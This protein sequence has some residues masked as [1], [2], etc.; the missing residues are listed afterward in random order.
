MKRFLLPLLLFGALLLFLGAGLRRDPRELPS[1]LIGKPVPAFQASRLDD[2]NATLA[3][4]DMQGRVWLLNV[5][6]SWCEACRAEHADL[7]ELSK[8]LGAPLVGLNYKDG[9][10]EALGWLQRYGNPYQQT[11]FDPDGRVGIEFG[12]YGVPETF[13]IDKRG[14]IRMKH[15]GPLNTPEA[16]ERLTKMVKEL[17]HA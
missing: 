10:A 17:E 13:V 7:M 4:A 1:A 3:A 5:W 15:L 9:R 2:A 8:T 11:A 6:A 12:V 16:R 14:I